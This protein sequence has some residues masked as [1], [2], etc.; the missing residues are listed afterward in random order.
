MFYKLGIKL[1]YCEAPER[2]DVK[3]NIKILKEIVQKKR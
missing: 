1:G 3:E 2:M